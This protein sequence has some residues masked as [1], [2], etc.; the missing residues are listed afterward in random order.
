MGMGR[1]RVGRMGQMW[2]REKEK[3]P[4]WLATERRFRFERDGRIKITLPRLRCLEDREEEEGL[5]E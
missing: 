1:S 3:V 4:R 5:E 2:K